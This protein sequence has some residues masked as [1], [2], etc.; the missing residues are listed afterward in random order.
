MSVTYYVAMPFVDSEE[1]PLPAE[2]QECPSEAMAKIRAEAMSRN[3]QYV[4]ALAFKRTGLPNEGQF[5][6][7]TIL[8]TYGLVPERIDEL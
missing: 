7:P 4:G 6:E 2:A 3:Q 8:G 1:G 5:G